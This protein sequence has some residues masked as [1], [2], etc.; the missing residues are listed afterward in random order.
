MSGGKTTNIMRQVHEVVSGNNCAPCQ[1][2]SNV[3][4]PHSRIEVKNVK[5]YICTFKSIN[6]KGRSTNNGKYW[7]RK[8][9]FE[10]S[11]RTGEK[12]I[13]H[14]CFRTYFISFSNFQDAD[15]NNNSGWYVVETEDV[16]VNTVITMQ[17]ELMGVELG[18]EERRAMGLGGA[19]GDE[20][21]RDASNAR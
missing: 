18:R 6:D 19:E 5:M 4:V 1:A 17:D 21:R 2:K 16:A 9:E 15:R 20:E 8:F 3:T 12:F 13:F 7:L 10:R 14:K 11:R